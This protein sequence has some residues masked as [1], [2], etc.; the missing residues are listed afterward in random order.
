MHESKVKCISQIEKA[1]KKPRYNL[2]K[3]ERDTEED[4]NKVWLY[5]QRF[6][7]LSYCQVC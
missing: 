6:D 5:N 3:R 7:F 1:V 4:V 2:K